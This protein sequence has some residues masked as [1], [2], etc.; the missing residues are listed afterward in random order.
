MN[1]ILAGL[2]S[3][4]QRVGTAIASSRTL[5]VM[6]VVAILVAIVYFKGKADG[7]A[8]L[9][10]YDTKKLPT[11]GSGVPDGFDQIADSFVDDL[12]NGFRE[13]GWGIGAYREAM[14]TVLMKYTNDMI[15]IIYNKYNARYGT[16]VGKTLTEEIDATWVGN[17]VQILER[18]RSLGLK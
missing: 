11:N 3:G 18:L 13:W 2:K 12:Y 16:K 8:S 7:K 4:A 14:Y 17:N 1:Q 5:Q 6:I 10:K 15:V 9:E